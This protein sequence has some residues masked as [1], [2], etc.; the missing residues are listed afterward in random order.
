MSICNVCQIDLPIEIGSS[1]I[2]EE[3]CEKQRIKK[4]LELGNYKDLPY[5]VKLL[6]NK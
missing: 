1:N 6:N 4:A 3:L 5:N 2:S